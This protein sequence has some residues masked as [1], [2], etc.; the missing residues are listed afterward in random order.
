MTVGNAWR[1]EGKKD[2]EILWGAL[3]LSAGIA[4]DLGLNPRSDYQ[5]FPI[6]GGLVYPNAEAYRILLLR[7]GGNLVFTADTAQ[8]C[9]VVVTGTRD[10]GRTV[11]PPFTVTI[12]EAQAAGWGA[13][14][15]L[16]TKDPRAIL[17]ARASRRAV[18]LYQPQVLAA[19]PAERWGDEDP[20][21]SRCR[22]ATCRPGAAGSR[23]PPGD[24]QRHHPTHTASRHRP[25]HPRTAPHPH[26]T[27]ALRAA[28]RRRPG[29]T[30][31]SSY[32][33][34][35]DPRRHRRRRPRLRRARPRPRARRRHLPLRPRRR[36]RQT[37]LT[38]PLTPNMWY[39]T[40]K[41]SAAVLAS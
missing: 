19:V 8:Q 25:A 14:S 35:P 40:G 33:P 28:A 11:Y 37:V 3:E 30:S 5:L 24:C 36:R 39:T 31:T 32:R 10:T 26:R 2:G 4:H 27:V 34:R 22:G 38:C 21:R 13:A 1:K 18:K 17:R 12:A 9:T 7:H 41:P 15:G 16:Q 20:G 29:S 23:H 6:I